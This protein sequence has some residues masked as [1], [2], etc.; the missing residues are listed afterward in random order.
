MKIKIH[1]NDLPENVKFN[2]S[3]AIDTETM[4]LNPLRDRLCLVQLTN[5]KGLCHLIKFDSNHRNAKNLVKILKNNKIQKIFHYARFD[6][7]VLN[8]TFNIDIQNIYCTKITSKLVRTFTDKHGYKDLCKELL[9]VQ[10]SKTEQTTDW[11]KPKL[12]LSQ[13]KYAANDV[14]YLHKIKEE[15]DKMLKREKRI[16]LAKAC[17]D[18][19]RYRTKLDLEGWSNQDIFSH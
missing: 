4:G 14:Y 5:G 15:L 8:H 3:V 11:G 12:T 6:V 17:F 1:N 13:Q 2:N 7:A 10:I 9:N 18:F 19:I 16:D